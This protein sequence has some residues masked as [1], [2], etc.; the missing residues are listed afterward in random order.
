MCLIYLHI[1]KV[2]LQALLLHYITYEMD[3]LV[4]KRRDYERDNERDNK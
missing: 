3:N 4:Q 1:R 2:N